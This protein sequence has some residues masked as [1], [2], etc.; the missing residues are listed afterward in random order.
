MKDLEKEIRNRLIWDNQIDDSRI[1]V[2]ITENKIT[3]KG[4]VNT[5]PE[6]VL[7]EIETKMIPEVKSVI[8][9]ID[10]HIPK[11]PIILDDEDIED[12]R[13][14]LLDDNSN[15]KSN[16]V[17]VLIRN[18]VI[19][20]EGKTNS[21]WKKYKIQKMIS[22]IPGINTIKNHINI[23]P[24]QPISDNQIYK[25][26]L[27]ALRNSV[28]VDVKNVNIKVNMGIVTLFGTV[29]SMSEHDA[30]LNIVQTTGG[31]MDII[32][33]LRWILRYETT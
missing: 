21:Y 31:V 15:I 10:V 26:L 19:K 3:L 9:D 22:Q 25:N 33:N 30:I 28:H 23:V 12:A 27:N 5:F 16:D 14:Y 1:K 29:S 8:N 11:S 24:S 7:A 13:S 4:Y 32:D 18:G 2:A 6:K 20:L 17:K